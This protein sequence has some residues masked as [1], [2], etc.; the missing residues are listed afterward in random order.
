[1]RANTI[2]ALVFWRLVDAANG[3]RIGR[4][5]TREAAVQYMQEVA[6]D[7]T[8]LY[9]RLSAP[10]PPEDL[11][12]GFPAEF[13]A[14]MKRRA[15]RYA[16]EAARLRCRFWLEERDDILSLLV[17]RDAS[18]ETQ[19]AGQTRVVRCEWIPRGQVAT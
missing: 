14:L 6:T 10:R 5:K 7:M 11:F 3:Q 13:V 12:A 8:A 15:P 4:F 2:S 9:D 17:Q 18:S 19:V 16:R 1:M